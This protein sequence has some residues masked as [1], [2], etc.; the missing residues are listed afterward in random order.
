M[1]KST[2]KNVQAILEE[3][4]GF[5]H[6]NPEIDLLN[7]DLKKITNSDSVIESLKIHQRLLRVHPNHN[8]AKALL[9][10][11]YTAANEIAKLTEGAFVKRHSKEL[12]LSSEETRQIH[13]QATH[14]KNKTLH[15]WAN[16][17][18][19]VHSAHSRTMRSANVG[20]D[21]VNYFE[22]LPSYQEL[23]G[24]LDYCSCEEC[25]SIFGPAAY[26]VD[27]MRIID[28][29]ITQ[30]NQGTI[31][32]ELQLESPLR[33]S[34]LGNIPLTCA[35]TNDLVPYLQIVNERLVD[36]V[37]ALLGLKAG[38]DIFQSLA[39]LPFPFNLPF[40]LPLNQ[41]RVYLSQMNIV[42]AD[43]YD[44]WGV[45]PIVIAREKLG[46][47]LEE[48]TI[49]T[50]SAAS[51]PSAYYGVSSGNL[52]NLVEVDQFLK[53]T[54][55]LYEN[56]ADLLTQQLNTDEL[57][58]S[59]SIADNF[60]INGGLKNAYLEINLGSDTTPSTITNLKDNKDAF[61]RLN[62]FIRLANKLNWSYDE[63]DWALRT[64]TQTGSSITID[65]PQIAAL[66]SIQMLMKQWN[67]GVLGICALLNR[68][69]TYGF[70]DT[71]YSQAQFDVIFNNPKI[72]GSLPPYHPKGD[73]LNPLYQDSLITW[74]PAGTDIGTI[75]VTAWLTGSLSL[76]TKDL[77]QLTAAL[78]AQTSIDL[79]VEN[80][81]IL[82][83]HA[84]LAALLQFSMEQY[85]IFINICNCKGKQ[86]FALDDLK[87]LI[88]IKSWLSSSGLNVYDLN[89][90]L[91]NANPRPYVNPLYTFDNATQINNW[92]ISIQKGQPQVASVSSNEVDYV[93][94]QINNY[95]GSTYDLMATLINI[96]TKSVPPPAGITWQKAFLT[97]APTRSTTPPNFPPYWGYINQV[98]SW[99]SRW[100]VIVNK[101]GITTEVMQ[102]LAI[103]PQ[104][105]GFDASFSIANYTVENIKDLDSF[106]GFIVSLKDYDN[107]FIQYISSFASKGSMDQQIKWLNQATGWDL[108]QIQ[109]L[110]ATIPTTL[111]NGVTIISLLEKA[112]NILGSLNTDPSFITLVQGAATWN[113]TDPQVWNNYKNL[114]NGVLSKIQSLYGSDQ[115]V[116]VSMKLSGAVEL[117]KRDALVYLELHQLNS[118]YSDIKTVNNVYEFL[119][120]DVEMGDDTQISY[121]KEAL[122]C[123]QLYLQRCRLRL[124][125]GIIDL[126][127][128]PIWWDWIMNYRIW[129]ANREVF[130]YPENYLVPS[131]RKSKTAIFKDLE[132]Q[133]M[134]VN[135]T[136][137]NVQ[138]A[139]INYIN[140]FSEIA[141]V[142]IVDSYY[143]TI[144]DPLKGNIDTFFLFGKKATDPVGFFLCQQEAGAQWSEWSQINLTINSEYIT[145][146]YAFNKLF[147]FWSEIKKTSSSSIDP[148]TSSSGSKSVTNNTY[149]LNINYS[150]QNL[151]GTWFAAQTLIADKVISYESSDGPS[152]IEQLAIFN[153]LFEMDSPIWSKVY[154]FKLNSSNFKNLENDNPFEKISILYGPFVD[155]TGQVV[156]VSPI[157]GQLDSNQKAF[158]TLLYSSANDY[159]RTII[160]HNDGYMPLNPLQTLNVNLQ[161]D[162][163]IFPNEALLLKRP[164]VN[165]KVSYSTAPTFTAEINSTN[166]YLQIIASDSVIYD[167]YVTEMKINYAPYE[168]PTSVTT[169]LINQSVS[170]LSSDQPQM[171]LNALS[172]YG[173][174]DSNNYVDDIFNSK[175][176]LSKVLGTIS[177]SADQINQLQKMLFQCMSS[178]VLFKNVA[179]KNSNLITVK[180][181]PGWLI[182]NNGDETFLLSLKKHKENDKLVP[183]FVKISDNAT[184]TRPLVTSNSF[185]ITS[186]IDGPTSS[187]ILDALRA[188][189]IIYSDQKV[190]IDDDQKI[191]IDLSLVNDKNLANA[192]SSVI[193][194]KDPD[195]EKKLTAIYNILNNFPL[196]F[197]DSFI[198]K[199]I[200]QNTSEQI[201]T[202]FLTYGIVDGGSR[203]D[204]RLVTGK[205]LSQ[206][207]IQLIAQGTITE[208]Q[209]PD[210]YDTIIHLTSAISYNYWNIDSGTPYKDVH[211]YVFDVTR[212]TTGAIHNLNQ[213]LT[214]VGIDRL[215]S[216]DSQQVPVKPVMPF[217]RLQPNQNN[218][219]FP[220]AIDGA[221]VDFD[222]LY[223]LYFWEIFY[224]IPLLVASSLNSNQQ[225]QYAKKWFE[226]IINPTLSE[227][228]INANTFWNETGQAFDQAT[229]AQIFAVLQKNNIGTPPAPILSTEGRVNPQFTVATDLSFLS[230]IVSVV[231]YGE[232]M[233]RNILLR[234]ETAT[235]QS[236]YWQF[237]PFRNH[238][239][240]SL[241]DML[242]DDN[243]AVQVY[244]DDPFDPYA[245]ADLRIGAYEKSTVMQYIDNLINWGD[246]L[247]TQDTWESIT[248]ATMLYVYAYDLLGPKPVDLGPCELGKTLSFNDIKS[249][250][251]K[252]GKDIPQFLI[253][254]ETLLK[255]SK[256]ISVNLNPPG[257]PWNELDTYFGVPE[258]DTL[259]QYWNIVEDRLYKIRHS[260]NI[261][262]QVRQL[263]LFEPPLNPMM[264][265]RAA[266]SSGGIAQALNYNDTQVPL[267]R[268][269]YIIEQAKSLAASLSQLGQSLLSA[270]EK[271]DSEDLALL[272]STQQSEILNLT[273]IIKNN[274]IQQLQQ[275][276]SA[277]QYA[278]DQAQNT[279]NYY[280]GLISGGL[281]VGE[282]TN[283]AA[284]AEALTFNVGA[285][286]LKT[287]ASLAYAVPQV[288]SPFAMTYGGEQVGHVIEAASH[289]PE[290]GAE[291]ANFI[292]QASLTVAGYDR[293]S[294]EWTLQQQSA[295]YEV[296]NLQQQISSL[297]TQIASAKQ[298]LTIHLKS[299][300][301]EQAVYNFLKNKFSSSDLYQWL[302]SNISVVY[303]QTYKLAIEIA[304]KAQKAYRFELNQDD[305]S[306]ISFNYW[307]SL[308]KGL[309][310][311]EMLSLALNQMETSYINNNT[312]GLEIEK[313]ISLKLIRPKAFLDLKTTGKCIFNLDEKLFDYDFPGQFARKIKSI[314]LSL[315]AVIGPYQNINAV[316]ALQNDQVL[317][318]IDDVTTATSVVQYL[319][320]GQG[321]KPTPDQG[322]RENW[323][324]NQQI[325]LSRGIDDTGMF[326][327]DFNDPRY[328]PFEGCGAV[329][330]WQ[331][332]IP[333]E[334]NRFNFDA[335]SDVIINLRYT[336]FD[337]GD[338]F[339]KKVEGLLAQNPYQGALYFNLN[340]AFSSAWFTFMN[341]HSS[342]TSQQ[343]LFSVSSNSLSYFL[344]NTVQ[345]NS[346]YLRLSMATGVTLPDET[347]AFISLSS[348]GQLIKKTGL[349]ADGTESIEN[350]NLPE[351]A[352][353][354]NWTIAIDLTAIVKTGLLD[355]NGFLDPKKFLN[356]ELILCYQGAIFKAQMNIAN[357]SPSLKLNSKSSLIP[358]LV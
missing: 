136:Q 175:I 140:S 37:S 294:Q 327:L 332:T 179:K 170:G 122:N 295:T 345:L 188:Y 127:I 303:F 133:L 81:S 126:E 120:I 298:D 220:T 176:D 102:S 289:V 236:H 29:Y 246:N 337:G 9:R 199:R 138:K 145:P 97:P 151:D 172:T 186:L 132:N 155:N 15:L 49:L 112:F 113:I 353:I 8:I 256:A 209:I 142:Q 71:E 10:S 77:N 201:Y 88:N 270:L 79:T 45:D 341:D 108:T 163:L 5:L 182:Y 206:V 118:K 185:F 162:C 150:F 340:Q 14:I 331:L 200:N 202:Y 324:P 309:M 31:P 235:P 20:D 251:E 330:T 268:F 224:H 164:N 248:E 40:N 261:Q 264:L 310:S 91:N 318:K 234:Y 207:L 135:I 167:N 82:Y 130:L 210:I 43:I 154:A 36:S 357:D 116:N 147:I 41:M 56:L 239:L 96:I 335:L 121:I 317:T 194:P 240:E 263:A 27:L 173:I 260:M 307:D 254:M 244:N 159:N 117:K 291:I 93:T 160:G 98:L 231:K 265:V 166:N 105:Y 247:F 38:Q 243:P 286:I 232:D 109:A 57:N 255:P 258:N 336:C 273:T 106:Q 168:Y 328:L 355:S 230:S 6:N 305:A 193:D 104:A 216:L 87:N 225:F 304:L 226:Y 19:V 178:L 212:L 282:I 302:I 184:L 72:L 34:D 311:G 114:A 223:K 191:F 62:R 110:L 274:Q 134:Q 217:D 276:V 25:N 329:S 63:L 26:F 195:K 129:E 42:L 290:L 358:E 326:I 68:L 65:A 297:Q 205:N 55:L 152:S 76:S 53:Q 233:V 323:V 279:Q 174:L 287:A 161:E 322:Y 277:M 213:S 58:T 316:L 30:A 12:N 18:S 321:N 238:T 89:Y 52:N 149:K 219:N 229:S 333:K 314:S 158:D 23:F 308:K 64:V 60:Y 296:S 92:V 227:L 253:E 73:P 94:D 17:K 95:F 284:M 183:A 75:K 352:F 196:A 267:Y 301:Q 218:I 100:L 315:P 99:I 7:A 67:K 351:S 46:I 306:F 2:K 33:R 11:G 348:N 312:R 32:Q 66:A 292:A 84:Q 347:T 119:L 249:F 146:I 283:L 334:T 143:C 74:I 325:A 85:L 319:L 22:N 293:R 197:Q 262:G 80:L 86:V 153:D 346:I 13:R 187:N 69:K 288:G 215:L 47:S 299:I 208:N 198:T 148:G 128:P 107:D 300:D 137:D 139:Y 51:D 259:M 313:T 204:M 111:T 278:L 59:P 257:H 44:L 342:K 144:N 245:I 266:A 156:T 338:P 169:A 16:A 271:K 272:H 4:D 356:L 280:N 141:K 39:T 125:Q 320:T 222:G 344:P 90:F 237:Q 101:L 214:L 48:Y 281:S 61:D 123:V 190:V 189:G 181:Q 275:S 250:Y 354:G 24:S 115:W 177:L 78:F 211:D 221:Q 242:S 70:G 50:T 203:I 1:K 131:I 54:D 28:K 83:R 35:K 343:I 21:V 180:N 285:S 192:L 103:N 157:T 350:L 171:I 228:F 3:I 241:T 124:E 269:T 339:R 349:K 252:E 165:D